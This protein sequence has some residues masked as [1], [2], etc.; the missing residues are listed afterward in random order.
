MTD[1]SFQ[2]G[3]E[4]VAEVGSSRHVTSNS[5]MVLTPKTSPDDKEI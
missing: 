5:K 2:T 1:V 4:Q 3:P